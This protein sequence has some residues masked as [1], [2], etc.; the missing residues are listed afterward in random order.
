MS[1]GDT[2]W[3]SAPG[4]TGATRADEIASVVSRALSVLHEHS[5][6]AP[7]GRRSSHGWVLDPSAIHDPTAVPG[8]SELHK[9]L[10][11][12]RN[13]AQD[14]IDQLVRALESIAAGMASG[15]SRAAHPPPSPTLETGALEGLAQLQRVEAV[16]GQA[17]STQF[18]LVNEMSH[19]VEVLMKA[20]SLIGPRGFEL[21]SHCVGFVPNPLIMGASATEPV[22]VTIGV[23][24]HAPPGE[25]SGLVQGVGLD[26]ASARLTVEVRPAANINSG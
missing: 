2:Y 25:Y 12:F 1:N 8:I 24:E 23:P 3:E 22:H 6:R 18:R 26:G 20:S 14:L 13:Q 9:Q 10:E 15:S 5:A 7:T 17:A 4:S 16:A 21:P 19:P 11:R